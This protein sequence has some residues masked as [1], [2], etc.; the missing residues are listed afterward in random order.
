MLQPQSHS[1]PG[2]QR[3]S[4]ELLVRNPRGPNQVFA[5]VQGLSNPNHYSRGQLCL[6]A[7]VRCPEFAV[8]NHCFR[9]LEAFPWRAASGLLCLSG[10]PSCR[11]PAKGALAPSSRP[12]VF[13]FECRGG[14]PSARVRAWA[15]CVGCGA[16]QGG[17]R[18]T[19]EPA[20][21]VTWLP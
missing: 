3:R 1:P 11:H 12:Q 17:K 13:S 10:S 7:A 8:G 21:C 16:S 9:S 6:P 2:G 18:G 14:R 4:A 15:G 19:M 5:K 20:G